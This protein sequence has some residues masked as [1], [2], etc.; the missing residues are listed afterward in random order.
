MRYLKRGMWKAGIAIAGLLLFLVLMVWV[1]VSAG[2][3]EGTS[4][5]AGP[6]T[7]TVQTTPTEDATATALSRE[8]LTLQ[9]KELQ[10]Q[11]QNQN[12]WLVNNSTALIAAVAT[13][14]VALF[15]ISQWAINR[16]DERR[17]EVATQDKESKDRQAAQDKD[18]RAQ[19]EERFKTAVTA[20]GDE[21]EGV[22]V[23]GTILLRSF[24]KD[25]KSYERYYTQ[26]FDLA[27]AY[28]RITRTPSPSD[29]PDGIPHSTED[30]DTPL[31]LTPLRQALIGVFK[32][33]FPL[34][35]LS[36]GGNEKDGKA[37]QSLDA[38]GIKLDNA[39][40]SKADLKQVW[41]PQASLREADLSHA[42]LHNA[43]LSH[44][45]L[46]MTPIFGADLSGAILNGADLSHAMLL[47]ANLRG[48]Y[49][50]STN[51]SYASLEKD[52]LSNKITDLSHT[53]LSGANFLGA[54]LREA[55][56]SEANLSEVDFSMADLSGA[57]LS[58]AILSGVDLRETNLQVASSIENMRIRNVKGL[59]KEQLDACRAKGAI[60]DEDTAISSPQPP[61]SPPTPEPRDMP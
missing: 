27:A 39:Y 28:L 16:R 20:L 35:R 47:G 5:L 8:Q 44:A 6:G 19:A 26:V 54:N 18:L 48:A 33:S 58:G 34:A 23:G 32:E 41:M 60:I 22:Q 57:N 1:P 29:D 43:N 56:L 24:L 11:L 13:V 50:V 51:L 21:N 10:N 2:A 45:K 30:S 61:V 53:M 59:T 36:A 40:L 9:V 46:I 12:N 37:L 4:G 31:P 55:N 49:L 14:V 3:Y 52:S 42:N 15:G 25:D 17:K 38:T 7:V